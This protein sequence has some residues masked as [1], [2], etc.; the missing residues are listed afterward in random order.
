MME[1][2]RRCDDWPRA[3]EIRG[4]FIRLRHSRN[5]NG[6]GKPPFSEVCRM[7]LRHANAD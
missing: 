4:F 6:T 1:Q 3:Q 7:I 5:R 2:Q